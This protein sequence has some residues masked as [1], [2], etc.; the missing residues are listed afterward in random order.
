MSRRVIMFD[1]G[2]TAVVY[3]NTDI[4]TKLSWTQVLDLMNTSNI[5][6]VKKTKEQLWIQLVPKSGHAQKGKNE[7]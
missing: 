1:D 7:R 4:R 6:P 2:K 3:K 5:V